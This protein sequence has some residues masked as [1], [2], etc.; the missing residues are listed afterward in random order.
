MEFEKSH[1]LQK[2]KVLIYEDILW[3]DPLSDL[4]LC[5]SLEKI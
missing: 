1:K 3:G 4:I 2:N 5:A